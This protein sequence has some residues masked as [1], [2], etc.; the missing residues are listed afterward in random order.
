MA[1]SERDDTKMRKEGELRVNRGM[2]WITQVLEKGEAGHSLPIYY[3]LAFERLCELTP[4]A[5]SN[6]LLLF[7][8]RRKLVS[9]H[10]P[11]RSERAT[12]TSGTFLA[13]EV[14]LRDRR[15]ATDERSLFTE[16]PIPKVSSNIDT[17]RLERRHPLQEYVEM[18]Q[19]ARPI[20]NPQ[21]EA[22]SMH[23]N[24]LHY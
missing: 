1:R 22:P 3:H 9:A 8:Q 23:L 5:D 24:V 14:L 16:L 10:V 19:R 12:R 18:P 21:H 4:P 7:T 17:N 6:G 2:E 20:T 13:P 11:S 15:Y